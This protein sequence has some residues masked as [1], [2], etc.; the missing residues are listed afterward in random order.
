MRPSDF[1][2]QLT[3]SLSNGWGIIRMITD[4]ILKMPE[5]KYL[6]IKDPNKVSHRICL[7][8]EVGN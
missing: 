1:I 2:T 8:S 3:V 4:K 6:L 7:I 5:G